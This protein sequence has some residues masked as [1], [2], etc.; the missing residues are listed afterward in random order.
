[1]PVVEVVLERT[2]STPS[3][4]SG[5]RRGTITGDGVSLEVVD[6]HVR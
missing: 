5:L 6:V 4:R 3:R 2:S 1:M